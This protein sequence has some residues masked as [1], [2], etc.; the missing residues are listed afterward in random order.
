MTTRS[1]LVATVAL[2]LTVAG[3]TAPASGEEPR[4]SSPAP[5]P[6]G[7]LRARAGVAVDA[8]LP[9]YPDPVGSLGS[10]ALQGEL[11]VQINDRWAVYMPVGPGLVF[12]ER[13]G[14]SVE[15]FGAL[16]EATLA[17]RF[18]I[19]GGVTMIA[20]A[21]TEHGGRDETPAAI[22]QGG[23]VRLTFRPV[24]TR[25]EPRG[26]RHGLA[27]GAQA[28]VLWVGLADFERPA[29][30]AVGVWPSVFVGYQAF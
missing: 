5:P 15:V 13:R 4:P 23:M 26:R 6:E 9:V 22:G 20:F 1:R 21:D 8:G 17:D 7:S 11:G 16:T 30:S 2:A 3:W 28:R 25:A 29:S 19:A 18:A 14:P 10:L 24:V 27:V 12:G